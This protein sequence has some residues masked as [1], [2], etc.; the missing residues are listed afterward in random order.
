MGCELTEEERIEGAILFVA[1][2]VWGA[3]T[4]ILFQEEILYLLQC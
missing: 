2:M 3:F 1:L 4:L